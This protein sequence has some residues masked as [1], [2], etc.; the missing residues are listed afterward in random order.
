M[1]A[2]V[3]GSHAQ[4]RPGRSRLSLAATEEAAC[5]LLGCRQEPK[6]HKLP[7]C[8]TSICA[9][10]AQPALKGQANIGISPAFNLQVHY[11]NLRF[12]KV[13]E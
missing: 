13:E 8:D 7:T 5:H 1:G 11:L 3:E 12:A 2:V 4:S 6:A 10:A 9:N